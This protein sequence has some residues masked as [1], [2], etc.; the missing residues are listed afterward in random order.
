MEHVFEFVDAIVGQGGDAFFA[1]GVDADDG[2]VADVAL[3]LN[4]AHGAL[5]GSGQNLVVD[6][7][8]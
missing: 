6:V 8:G 7:V 3:P 1:S 4:P 2:A 5:G